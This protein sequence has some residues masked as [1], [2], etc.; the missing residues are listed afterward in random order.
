MGRNQVV[1]FYILAP[2]PS[3][4]FIFRQGLVL[5]YSEDAV[6]SLNRRFSFFTPSLWFA[7]Q[8]SENSPIS[9]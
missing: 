7:L 9:C 1:Y 8:I 6:C 5:G 2:K 3:H 4:I